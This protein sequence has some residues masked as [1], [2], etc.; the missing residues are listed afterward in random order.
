MASGRREHIAKARQL[1]EQGVDNGK[2][3]ADRCGFASSDVM[4]RTFVRVTGLTPT[5]YRRLVRQ[6]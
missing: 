4:R 6:A 5:L 2:P 3:R 1:M